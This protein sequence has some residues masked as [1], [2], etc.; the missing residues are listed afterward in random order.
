MSATKMKVWLIQWLNVSIVGGSCRGIGVTGGQRC[1]QGNPIHQLAQ[2]MAA[3]AAT[4]AGIVMWRRRLA[5]A[6]GEA[7][8]AHQWRERKW[9]RLACGC[10]S[11]MT[12]LKV[13][14][15]PAYV[16]GS[17]AARKAGWRQWL[18]K[19]IGSMAA[20]MGW[21][22]SFYSCCCVTLACCACWHAAKL[23][24]LAEMQLAWRNE[25]MPQ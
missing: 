15:H 5:A 1:R 23:R 4:L 20:A 17:S 22:Y 19:L 13:M 8:S 9:R 3:Y 7:K 21:Q 6:I 24:N 16:A 14:R 2:P 11:E 25:I 12:W 18:A 10:R